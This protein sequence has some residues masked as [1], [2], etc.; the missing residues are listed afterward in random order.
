MAEVT[1]EQV[2]PEVTVE[3]P[4]AAEATPEPVSTAEPVETPV[5][6]P[7]SEKMLPQSEVNKLIA[8]EKAQAERRAAKVARAEAERDFY[9]KQL[10]QQHQP[11]PQGEPNPEDFQ[12]PKQYVAAVVKHQLAQ[13]LEAQRQSQQQETQKQSQDRYMSDRAEKVRERLAAVADE[14]PDI[15]EVVS[16]NVPFTY[17][18]IDCI[19]DS[20]I[21]GKIAHYLGTNVKEA[22]RIANLPPVG[23]VRELLSLESRLKAP[24]A[25]TKMPAPIVPNPGKTTVQK[26]PKDMSDK[27]FAEW[28]RRQIA[29]RR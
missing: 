11:K 22:A 27:E 7:P 21:G 26:D 2:T 5:E 25:T 28:R 15:E 29:Q 8:R 3:T 18:M 9:R 23:Q 14:Y 12:D 17:P 16:G 20:D 13:E 19:A 1:P 4:V 6:A 10:E 24:P